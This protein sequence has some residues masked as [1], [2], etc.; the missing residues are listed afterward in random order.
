MYFYEIGSIAF[1]TVSSHIIP[2][3][4]LFRVSL[5]EALSYCLSLDQSRNDQRN[6]VSAH[7]SKII[8]VFKTPRLFL[9]MLVSEINLLESLILR[10]LSLK[11]G[12]RRQSVLLIAMT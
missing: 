11:S 10:I 8:W 2:G 3:V 7:Q 1:K 4:S 9:F 12:S 5:F 6:F